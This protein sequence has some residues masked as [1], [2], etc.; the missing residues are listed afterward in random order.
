MTNDDRHH[1]CPDFFNEKRKADVF[2][3][4]LQLVR[5]E[6]FLSHY[7]LFALR[8][9]IKKFLFRVTNFKLPYAPKTLRNLR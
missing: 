7:R 8:E 5:F 9:L 4:A 6:L 1:S 3:A 2:R